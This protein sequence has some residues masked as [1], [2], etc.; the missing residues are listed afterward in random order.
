MSYPAH[1]LTDKQLRV[2][3]AFRKTDADSLA[4]A[5]KLGLSYQAV[6]IHKSNLK[7]K[8]G[9]DWQWSSEDYAPPVAAAKAPRG[10]QFSLGQIRGFELAGL[11]KENENLKRLL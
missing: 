5:L 10:R 6:L 11:L 9:P 4:V 7:N 8:L 1:Q 2:Y 3:R